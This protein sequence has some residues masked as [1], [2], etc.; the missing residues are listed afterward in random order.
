MNGQMMPMVEIATT[1]EFCEIENIT[2]SLNQPIKLAVY[3]KRRWPYVLTMPISWI[4]TLYVMIKKGI[5]KMFGISS[6]KINTLWFDGLGLE[7]P[8]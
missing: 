1:P 3:E 5:C 4:L 6:P 2:T 8:R 7:L